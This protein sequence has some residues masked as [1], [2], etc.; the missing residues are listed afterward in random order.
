MKNLIIAAVLLMPAVAGAQGNIKLG[1]LEINPFVSTQETYDSNIYLTNTQ[2]K[3][4]LINRTAFGVDLK[5]NLGSRYNLKGGYSMEL[6]GYSRETSINNATHHNANIGAT[7]KLPKDITVMV[8]DKWK[9]TTDQSTSQTIERAERIENVMGLNV[10]APLRSKFGFSLAVN[11]IYNNYLSST[12]GSLD[13]EEILMGFDLEY[14]WQ[15]KTKLF[16]AYRHG[17]LNYEEGYVSDATHENMELGI[18]GNIAPKVQ[19]TVKAGVQIRKYDESLNSADD[20]ITTGGY[21]AQAVWKPM[22]K[23]EVTLF[24]KRAN[25]ESNYGDSRF[26][27]STL[28]DLGIT[29]EIGKIKAGIG[30]NYEGVL[31]SEKYDST[32]ATDKVRFDENASVRLTA[33]YSI[34]KWLK[35]DF[36]YIYKDRSSNFDNFEYKDNMISLG[37]KATF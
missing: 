15:P 19:G 16:F 28:T 9:Q 14:K 22:E 20:E 36:A 37:L 4:A 35:A 33:E 30:M 2:R 31:Y 1:N 27:T 25:V 8:E 24:A 18:T 7:G 3:S 26:Y 29:R 17:I 12:L 11:H 10:N 21:S 6:L 5:E 23:T 32:D 13:R 34:Q